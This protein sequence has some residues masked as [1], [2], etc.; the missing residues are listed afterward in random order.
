MANVEGARGTRKDYAAL[1]YAVIEHAIDV[2]LGD[3]A[4]IGSGNMIPDVILDRS[5]R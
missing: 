1:C 2:D 4:V 3:A 5:I